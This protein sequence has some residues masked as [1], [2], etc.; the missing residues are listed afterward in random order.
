[1]AV[2]QA[3]TAKQAAQEIN[4]REIGDET[5]DELESA[6][7]A[8]GLVAAFGASDDLLELRGA[9]YDEVGA[10]KGTTV[11]LD[12]SGLIT[13]QCDN[14]D[15]PHEK[16]RMAAAKKSA[17]KIE[18]VWCPKNPDCSWLIKTDIPHETFDVMED[19]ELY[20]RGVVFKLAD[21]KA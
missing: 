16:M 9:I 12:E 19:G 11:L 15:C 10:Y 20:C 17:K 18:A 6:M 13:R 21:A 5:A 1:M 8:A 2:K 4:G 14:K 7:K 3:M